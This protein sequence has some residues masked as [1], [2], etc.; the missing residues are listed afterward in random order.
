[1]ES[2]ANIS[3]SRGSG[4]GVNFG[5]VATSRRGASCLC[6]IGIDCFQAD[7][8]EHSFDQ[9][10]PMIVADFMDKKKKHVVILPY[11]CQE[12]VE[13]Y[14]AIAERMKSFPTPNVSCDFLLASSPRTETSEELVAAFTE[15]GTAVAFACPTQIFGKRNPFLRMS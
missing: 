13:R 6:G 9:F 8:I 12:E 7:K 15:L 11:F 10:I 1:M 3:E 4:T 5:F 14:L 2:I